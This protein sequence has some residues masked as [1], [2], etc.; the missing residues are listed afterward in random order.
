MLN[1]LTALR[2]RLPIPLRAAY[3][4]LA[5]LSTPRAL[6]TARIRLAR[7][8][9]DIAQRDH[10]ADVSRRLR[11]SLASR[12][13]QLTTEQLATLGVMARITG[14][15]DL[16]AAAMV[17]PWSTAAMATCVAAQAQLDESVSRGR[18]VSAQALA[19]EV[20]GHDENGWRPSACMSVPA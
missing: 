2:S 17:A 16:A 13:R 12:P 15:R 19:I 4:R 6:V 20:R 7:I 18:L 9:R 14:D 11:R 5:A 3:L 10:I 1:A 8:A